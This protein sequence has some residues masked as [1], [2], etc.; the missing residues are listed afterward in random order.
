MGFRSGCLRLVDQG[1][2]LIN[3]MLG[4]LKPFL[5]DTSLLLVLADRKVKAAYELAPEETERAEAC[6]IDGH[7]YCLLSQPR[8]EAKRA[9]SGPMTMFATLPAHSAPTAILH[10]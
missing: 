10:M 8:A 3:R 2:R 1:Q 7:W 4:T 9:A 6:F 5:Q